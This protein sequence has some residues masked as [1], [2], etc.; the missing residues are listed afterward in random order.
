MKIRTVFKTIVRT[1]LDISILCIIGICL[2][3]IVA[4]SGDPENQ[5]ACA[6]LVG[7]CFAIVYIL[8]GAVEKLK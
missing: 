8:W 3:A 5:L 1:I 6:L 4:L 2:F 7:L